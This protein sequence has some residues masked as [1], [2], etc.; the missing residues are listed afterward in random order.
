MK[1]F[2]DLEDTVIDNW[3]SGTPV[4]IPEVKFFLKLSD[5]SEV[6]LFS[7]AV[8][9]EGD[10]FDF[11]KRLQPMLERELDVRFTQLLT[12]HDMMRSDK[13]FT[14]IHFE[15]LREF[16]A[17]RG[18]NDAFVNWCLANEQ[19]EHSVLVDDIVPNRV[20]V[21]FDSKTK[22]ETINVTNITRGLHKGC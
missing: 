3:H 11:Q 7:F 10:R 1:V 20:M 18:K 22:I 21:D 8:W 19:G 12:C 16:I 13:F 2:L 6:S 5:V 14:Q 9:D 15:D 4:N 17:M